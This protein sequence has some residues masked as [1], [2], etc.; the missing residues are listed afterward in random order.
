MRLHTI[1]LKIRPLPVLEDEALGSQPF[2][3]W[4]GNGAVIP[5]VTVAVKV[6]WNRGRALVLIGVCVSFFSFL[7][8]TKFTH[9]RWPGGTSIWSIPMSSTKRITKFGLGAA[10]I[11]A[12]ASIANSDILTSDF[13]DN[14]SIPQCF[15]HRIVLFFFFL[16]KIL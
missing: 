12:P 16:Q 10:A 15:L 5:S 1:S 4:R 13:E 6:G 8:E 3:V 7:E 2:D 14:I 11:A 9:D